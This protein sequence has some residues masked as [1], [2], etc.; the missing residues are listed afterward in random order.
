MVTE[1]VSL[2]VQGHLNPNPMPNVKPFALPGPETYYLMFLN[3]GYGT[4]D[5]QGT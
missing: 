4:I 2:K 3:T 5:I 1:K